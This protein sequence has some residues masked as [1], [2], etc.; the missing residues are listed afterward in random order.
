MQTT[1]KLCSGDDR[2]IIVGGDDDDDD[3][4]PFSLMSSS[5]KHCPVDG[6]PEKCE[7]FDGGIVWYWRRVRGSIKIAAGGG[8]RCENISTDLI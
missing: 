4:R 3:E 5:W 7:P 6:M 2:R 8:I 1:L